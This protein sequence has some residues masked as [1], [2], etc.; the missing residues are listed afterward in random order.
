M[1]M[2]AERDWLVKV[3]F[4]E[5]RERMSQR[6]LH[7]VDVDL[8]WGVTK[9]EAEQG[10]VL[11]VIL[12]EIDRSRP[13]FIALLGERYGSITEKVPDDTEFAYPWLRD[14]PGHSFTALEIVHG[15]LRNPSLTPRAFFYFRD[16]NFI[17]QIPTSKRKDFTA[18]NP[19]SA[20]KL[21]VLKEEI[22]ASGRPV[23]KNYPACWDNNQ[24][25]VVDLDI[26]G[27]RV[28][29][30]LWLAICAEYPKDAPEVDPLTVE[31]HM[32]DSFAEERARFHVGRDN[33]SSRLTQYVTGT[34]R[35]PVVITG[36]HGSGKSAFLASWYRK[37]AVD[38]PNDFVL[39]YFIGA[40]PDS[41]QY[42]RLLRN[43]CDELKRQFNLNDEIPE[44]AKELSEA[45]AV[46]L[47]TAVRDKQRIVLVLDA[48]G[49]W[50]TTQ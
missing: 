4:P 31:R 21:T 41:T 23:M 37:F 10:K 26:F 24:S 8:R 47:M 44:G 48:L 46:L 29:E 39:A 3:V 27:Q 6:N 36:E 13:F 14:Y 7:L 5:L 35:R 30:D 33:E 11:E 19:E 22:R 50:V 17:S 43:M 1:D 12:N 34:D 45:L 9:E 28:L 49:A 18:E 16:P 25:R 20:V 2:Q 38:H 15:V 42:L 40:S 32:H